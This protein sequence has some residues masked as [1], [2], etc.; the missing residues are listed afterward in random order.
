MCVGVNIVHAVFLLESFVFI[1]VHSQ[2]VKAEKSNVTVARGENITLKWLLKE[3]R[4]HNLVR[5]DAYRGDRRNE[6]LLLF[7]FNNK[8]TRFATE[9]FKNR[10]SG[11]TIDNKTKYELTI[12]DVQY[13]DNGPFTIFVAFM[14]V[15]NAN[16]NVTVILNVTGS[17][18]I[19]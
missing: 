1:S 2:E 5:V 8:L 3:G 19:F 6:S 17:Y 14:G 15:K 10:V 11:N 18:L 16:K 4:L 7:D 13:R 12:T 9:V